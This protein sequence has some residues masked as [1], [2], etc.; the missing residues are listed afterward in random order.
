MNGN[1]TFRRGLL[2]VLLA[3]SSVLPLSAQTQTGSWD[4]PSNTNS[5]MYILTPDGFG[6]FALSISGIWTGSGYIRLS[7]IPDPEAHQVFS[8]FNN[9]SQAPFSANF[10]SE[11]DSLTVYISTG[12][13]SQPFLPYVFTM[14]SGQWYARFRLVNSTQSSHSF[15]ITKKDTEGNDVAV[16]SGTVP[17]GGTSNVTV[18]ETSNV[19]RLTLWKNVQGAV[20]QGAS[21]IASEGTD[22]VEYGAAFVV[23]AESPLLVPINTV[24]F[25]GPL[26]PLENGRKTIWATGGTELNAALFREGIDKLNAVNLSAESGSTTAVVAAIGETNS[27]LGQVLE[28]VTAPVTD[29]AAQTATS[30]FITEQAS[31]A[32]STATGY[33][34]SGKT[35][36]E[37]ALAAIPSPTLGT[38][39]IADVADESISVRINPSLVIEIPKNPFSASGP[40]GGILATVAAFVRALITWGIVSAF[41]LWVMA[42]LRTTIAAPFATSSLSDSVA[43]SLNSVKIMGTGGGL[44]YAAKLGV[45]VLVAAALVTF[46]VALVATLTGS[47]ALPWASLAASF[48]S[49]PGDLNPGGMLGQSIALADVVAP[50]A[51][52]IFTPAYYFAVRFILLPSQF[53]WM[54]FIK[55][56]PA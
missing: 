35:E 23:E 18:E 31:G 44:G 25:G 39:E 5:N 32:V 20:Y 41:F 19:G 15:V 22:L 14:E 3:V 55:L 7:D 52:L 11:T 9:A 10:E 56:L 8:Y 6:G 46:P 24:D 4:G 34:T 12:D 45:V 50:M 29:G 49:G 1:A 54:L 16:S 13:V 43:S 40:F 21:F 37:T 48:A 28:Q 38:G 36:I 47:S 51:L 27:I 42:E 26:P 53:F 30:S 33:A 2:L 17:A